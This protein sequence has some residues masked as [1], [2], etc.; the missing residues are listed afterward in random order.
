MT[1]ESSDSV[2]TSQVTSL[3]TK[4]LEAID[5]QA[6]L[7]D[8]LQIVRRTLD[9]TRRE[10]MAYEDQ[11]KNREFVSAVEFNDERKKRQTAEQEITKLKAEIEELTSSLFDEAN[12][13]VADANMEKKRMELRLQERDGLIEN[14]R[15]ELD[16]LKNV[17]Q[18]QQD[19]PLDSSIHSLTNQPVSNTRPFI[20]HDL[21]SYTEFL[22]LFNQ[23][24]NSSSTSLATG[25]S[26][27][28]ASRFQSSSSLKDFKF[29]KRTFTDDIEPTLH[30]ESAPGL[31]WLSRRNIMSGILDGSIIIE[32]IAATNEN[33]KLRIDLRPG[34]NLIQNS[35]KF[36]ATLVSKDGLPVAT[37]NPCSM[38]GE[39]RDDNLLYARLHNLKTTKQEQ[40]ELQQQQQQQ[41]AQ[42]Q[43]E[44]SPTTL[45]PTSSS[46]PS[47]S[48][49]G[50]PLC[51]QCLN[52]VRTVCDYIS[53]V[54]GLRAGFWK[55]DK[56]LK[57]WE[58]CCTLRERMFWARCGMF[59]KGETEFIDG[60]YA[61]E[62]ASET[63]DENEEYQSVG[64]E[65]EEEEDEEAN[66]TN[67]N[68][69][70]LQIPAAALV[71]PEDTKLDSSPEIVDIKESQVGNE[72][73]SGEEM[74]VER[75][76]VKTESDLTLDSE[77]FEQSASE[78]A[79]TKL[80]TT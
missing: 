78:P 23:H 9:K 41:Q 19:T 12:R 5:K 60:E 46:N 30:L 10:N 18:Q 70:L 26:T 25:T 3:S 61:P 59:V 7:E 64:S 6:D 17:L 63:D 67:N 42:Q 16:G 28:L 35:K 40:N 62:T 24:S 34:G 37:R 80:S 52:R 53:F 50:Y 31:S 51:F 33:Y 15:E 29:F 22:Q 4:L 66:N 47:H 14:M 57:A 48:L 75:V 72:S 44:D 2:L 79:T 58:E 11:I 43:Q 76:Q 21:Q 49:T 45:T 32:P 77:N 71:E 65:D 56:G 27:G 13:M 69:T 39:K 36:T 55:L 68:E 20:R 38:C 74:I 1:E 8:Q 54:R 73:E